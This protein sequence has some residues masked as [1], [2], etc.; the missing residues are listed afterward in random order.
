MRNKDLNRLYWLNKDIERRKE[1]IEELE[2]EAERVTALLSGMPKSKGFG[3]RLTRIVANIIDEKMLIALKTEELSIERRNIE[4]YLSNVDDD[5]IRYYMQLRYID[6]LTWQQ[7]ANK[8]GNEVTQ[9][10]VKMAVHR[11]LKKTS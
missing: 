1:R 3:H 9:E 8:T 10:C 2:S 6:G 5:K 11:Y 4:Y 7:I